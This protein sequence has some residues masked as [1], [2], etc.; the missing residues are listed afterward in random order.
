MKLT[1]LLEKH[2]NVTIPIFKSTMKKELNTFNNQHQGY[3]P[4]LCHSGVSEEQSWGFLPTN[5]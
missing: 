2:Q 3:S 4:Y 5:K 1:K